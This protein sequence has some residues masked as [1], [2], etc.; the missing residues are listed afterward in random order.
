[1]RKLYNLMIFSGLALGMS[2][3]SQEIPTH[4]L[5]NIKTIKLFNGERVS[6][7]DQ[8]SKVHWASDRLNGIEFIELK[9]GMIVDSFDVEQLIL[10]SGEQ[11]RRLPRNINLDQ[12]NSRASMMFRIG[13]GSGG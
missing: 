2:A 11:T 9:D 7:E 10:D 1:M 8:V 4:L 13:D 3:Y 6:F 5:N 12:L